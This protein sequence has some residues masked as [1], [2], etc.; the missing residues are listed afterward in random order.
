VWLGGFAGEKVP[1][2]PLL[3]GEHIEEPEALVEL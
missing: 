1:W 2:K 3:M